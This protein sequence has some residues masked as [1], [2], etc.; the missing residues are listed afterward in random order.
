VLVSAV[1]L[2]IPVGSGGER[3]DVPSMHPDERA[4]P[5]HPKVIA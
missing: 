3:H 2:N 4:A 5:F 1:A